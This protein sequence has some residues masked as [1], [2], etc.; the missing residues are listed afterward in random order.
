MRKSYATEDQ[1]TAA[2]AKAKAVGIDRIGALAL[3]PSGTIWIFDASLAMNARVDEIHIIFDG[4]PSHESGRFVE[5]ETPDGRSISVGDWRQRPDGLW[6]L[7]IERAPEAR[8]VA[9]LVDALEERMDDGG[10]DSESDVQRRCY[11]LIRR[12]RPTRS[13]QETAQGVSDRE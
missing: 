2:V 5:V 11:E 9:E 8:A 6:A 4:P 3:S 10:A 13:A 12:Y 1:V 7:V